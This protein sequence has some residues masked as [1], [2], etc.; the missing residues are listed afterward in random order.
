MKNPNNLFPAM[1]VMLLA[2]A[3]FASW[4]GKSK[5]QETILETEPGGIVPKTLADATA[6]R[7]A[8]DECDR[9]YLR[10]NG[11]QYGYDNPGNMSL[12]GKKFN[13]IEYRSEQ[14]VAVQIQMHIDG[15]PMDR[16]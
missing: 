5:A 12:W 9:Q 6:A 15:Q 14:A 10:D 3:L 8:A 7:E 2:L 13:G 1:L 4:N 11:W 16:P